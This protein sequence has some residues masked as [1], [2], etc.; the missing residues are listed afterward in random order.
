MVTRGRVATMKM[1]ITSGSA[2]AGLAIVGTGLA[3]ALPEQKWMGFVLIGISAVVFGFDIRFEHGE[4]GSGE[5]RLGR[6]LHS[7]DRRRRMIALICMIISGPI[8]VGSAAVYFWPRSTSL[9][10]GSA[11]ARLAALGWTIKPGENSIRFEIASRAL[12]PM[13]QSADLFRQI[14]QPFNLVLQSVP[15][16]EGLHYL[17]NVDGC[18]EIAISAG[19]FTDISE[20][21]DFKHLASL[22]ISQVP[23][24]LIR[25]TPKTTR[26]RD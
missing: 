2:S 14:K 7:N 18:P 17:S 9:D 1:K 25:L 13:E 24:M 12:P 22:I 10:E 16:L 3:M 15:G 20:L 6:L 21:R 19:E 26:S 11:L 5:R 8:F 4:I 23:L